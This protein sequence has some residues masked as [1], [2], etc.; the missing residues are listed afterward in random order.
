VSPEGDPYNIRVVR[1]LGYGLDE[2]A[3]NAVKSSGFIPAMSG[4]VFVDHDE[5]IS[6]NFRLPDAPSAPSPAPIEKPPSSGSEDTTSQSGAAINA[7]RTST[8]TPS[9]FAARFGWYVEIIK[10]TVAQNWYSQLAD[11]V[12]SMGHSVVVSFVVN[13]DGS[14]SDPRIVQ[15]S[16]VPSL[17]LSAIQAVE[18]VKG[19]GP[20]PVGYSGD[21]ASV[22][23]TFTYDQNTT[24][25]K[26]QQK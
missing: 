26:L 23:Y 5:S 8:M 24:S 19:L 16:G 2:N 25:A 10:R 9:D 21:S 20:L 18:R 7:Q 11:P 22:S 12:A 3:V 14:I 13:R 17:D 4:G 1:S 15:S 6:F